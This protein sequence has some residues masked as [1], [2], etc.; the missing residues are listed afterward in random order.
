MPGTEVWTEDYNKGNGIDSKR[1]QYGQ[2][3]GL[4]IALSRHCS[5]MPSTIAGPPSSPRR[6]RHSLCSLNATKLNV[7]KTVLPTPIICKIWATWSGWLHTRRNV[8]LLGTKR[9][10]LPTV[11]FNDLQWVP[12]ETSL[13]LFLWHLCQLSSDFDS[14]WQKLTR[15]NLKHTYSIRAVWPTS[16]TKRALRIPL[17]RPHDDT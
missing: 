17:V 14:F 5:L 4:G 13:C 9:Q 7:R 1:I 11:S 8:T 16:A 10:I 12:Q 2:A 6:S 3:E 15:R